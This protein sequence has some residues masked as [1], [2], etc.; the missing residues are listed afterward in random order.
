[1]VGNEDA[2]AGLLPA[3]PKDKRHKLRHKELSLKAPFFSSLLN[4]RKGPM[5]LTMQIALERAH[6][7]GAVMSLVV[8]PFL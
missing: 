1:M 3:V 5:G 6:Q 4:C 7:K 8:S 2:R